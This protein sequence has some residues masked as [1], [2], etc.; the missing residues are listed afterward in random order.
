MDSQGL[1][2][3]IVIVFSELGDKTFFIAALMAMQHAK[4]SVIVGAF[5]ANVVM[6]VLSA[7]VGSMA[8]ALQ[9][10]HT[11]YLSV[12]LLLL[13][14]ARMIAEGYTMN[15]ADEKSI[16]KDAETETTQSSSYLVKLAGKSGLAQTF[17]LIFV[18]EWGD[19]S[20]IT[21]IAMAANEG[22]ARVLIGAILGHGLCVCVAV[23]GGQL[24]AHKL[25]IRSVTFLGGFVF[26]L[27]AISSV[28][29]GP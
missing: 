21:T 10:S 9:K 19:R 5:S 22:I 24:V 14:G 4:S 8:S 28:L 27:F 15:E 26:L 11:H 16:I 17:F 18:G 2:S 1:S 12:F 23:Y 29:M 6:T 3:V 13:F 25:S 20:Q 7:M